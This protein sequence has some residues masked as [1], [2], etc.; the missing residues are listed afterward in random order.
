[1]F[2][3][4]L[5]GLQLALL[6]QTPTPEAELRAPSAFAVSVESG[7]KLRSAFEHLYNLEFSAGRNLFRDVDRLAKLNPA[8]LQEVARKYLR[9]KNRTVGRLET[10]DEKEPGA[11]RGGQ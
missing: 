2:H 11:E 1:M 10:E 4:L 5:L 8:S 3:G 7:H 6:G 9:Q